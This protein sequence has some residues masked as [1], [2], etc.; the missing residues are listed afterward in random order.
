MR[1]IIKEGFYDV[2]ERRDL[3]LVFAH[4]KNINLSQSYGGPNSFLR[5]MVLLLEGDAPYSKRHMVIRPK[6]GLLSGKIDKSGS[7]SV[8][9]TVLLISGA[10]RSQE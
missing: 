4:I 9:K 2:L 3:P 10:N 6:A 5:Q 8:F 1:S 7:P